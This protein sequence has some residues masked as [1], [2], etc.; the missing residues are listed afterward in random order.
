MGQFKRKNGLKDAE[1]NAI[2]KEIGKNVWDER[3]HTKN[4]SK[5]EI[6]E[7]AVQSGYLVKQCNRADKFDWKDVD[8]KFYI[9]EARKLIVGSK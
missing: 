1:F 7:T 5:Y 8:W 2:M 9:D 4:K 3:V 6:R